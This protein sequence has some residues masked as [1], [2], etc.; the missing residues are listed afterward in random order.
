MA[1]LLSSPGRVCAKCGC[2]AG[3][4]AA[5]KGCDFDVVRCVHFGGQYGVAC[6][7]KAVLLERLGG[8]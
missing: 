3:R 5:G 6:A 2:V 7:A 1:A 4:V 8:W